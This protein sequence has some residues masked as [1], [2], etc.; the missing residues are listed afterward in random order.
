[1]W[2]LALAWRLAGTPF[3][4]VV[5]FSIERYAV[6]TVEDAL[7]S[8]VVHKSQPAGKE[9]VRIATDWPNYFVRQQ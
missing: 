2:R 3:R 7:A 9:G 8:H 6:C 4:N 5:S 1:M